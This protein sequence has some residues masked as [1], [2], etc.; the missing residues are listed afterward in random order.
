MR[1]V[2]A[3]T[4]F[5]WKLS[6][7]QQVSSKYMC[8]FFIN[9]SL[10]LSWLLLLSPYLSLS[11]FITLTK[12]SHCMSRRSGLYVGQLYGSGA[13]PIWLDDV[14]CTGNEVSLAACAHRGWGAH[15]CH[16][17]HDV[18][19]AC[20]NSTS[21]LLFVLCSLALFRSLLRKSYS[22]ADHFFEQL[23]SSRY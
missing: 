9:L 2:L 18:S 3:Y 22:L 15:N 20:G 10:I 12:A 17:G 19:I 6:Q 14:D 21:K 13:G 16:H 8:S 1:L 4:F 5:E 23:V 7:L 11:L